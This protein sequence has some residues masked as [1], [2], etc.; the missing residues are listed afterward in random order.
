MY[1]KNATFDNFR[2]IEKYSFDFS[3]RMNILFGKNAQGKTN[4]I[5]GIYLFAGGKSFR[6]AKDA[7]MRKFGSDWSQI[8][9]GF[10]TA[11][12]EYKMAVRYIG[13][14]KQLF[15]ND[16]KI[17]TLSDFIGTFRAVL[18][19]PSHLSIVQAEPGV[20]RSFI[21]GALSQLKPRYL[22]ELIEYQKLLEEKNAL[23]KTYEDNPE[24]FDMMYDVITEKMAQNAAYITSVRASYLKI[25]FGYV[26]NLMSDMSQGKEKIEYIYQNSIAETSSDL[27]NEEENRKAYALAVDKYREKE[28]IVGTSLFGCHRDDFEILLNG[29]PAKVFASQGQQRSIALA[30]KL[31]EGEISK[32]ECGEYPV[33][34]FDDVLSELDR[35]RKDYVLSKLYERQVIITSC[36]ENDFKDIEDAKKIYVENGKYFPM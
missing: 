36:D 33:F 6:H 26:N 28:K 22:A 13:T 8:N 20:R 29:K 3:P 21:D 16:V 34:L 31:A 30:I 18:F 15:R 11:D 25:L 24:G 1:L 7:D 19:C 23:L 12:R 4:V 5:E 9:I 35:E 14:R 10:D 27:S 17:K 32:N 2:N